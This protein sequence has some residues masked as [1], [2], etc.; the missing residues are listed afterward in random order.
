M[1]EDVEKDQPASAYAY[2]LKFFL[3]SYL[4]FFS[5][6]APL[7]PGS[8]FMM[9][10]ATGSSNLLN[11]V[12][13]SSSQKALSCI[14]YWLANKRDLG[15][16]TFCTPP[17]HLTET[18][19]LSYVTGEAPS[20]G[21]SASSQGNFFSLIDS[22][23][24]SAFVSVKIGFLSTE[25]DHLVKDLFK[26]FEIFSFLDWKVGALTKKIEDCAAPPDN[27]TADWLG[28]LSCVDEAFR[29]GSQELAALFTLG[30]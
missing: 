30:C 12:L 26:V 15:K 5:L 9:R 28:V 2:L 18:R 17:S 19:Y 25:L 7:S 6:M 24:H 11:M 16:A 1:E 10:Q 27:F 4:T 13:S 3:F 22:T 14:G 23:R 29:D 20:L 8:A 21:V